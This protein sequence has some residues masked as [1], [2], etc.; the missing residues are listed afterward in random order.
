M[1]CSCRTSPSSRPPRSWP[2]S[3]RRRSSSMCCRTRSTS[4]PQASSARSRSA[5]R[6][7]LR[8]RAV[9]PVDLFGQPADY[10]ALLPIARGSGAFRPLR[11]GAE[12]RR[13]PRRRA[14]RPLRPRHGDELLSGEAA[15][16]LRRRRR[17]LHRRRRAR[18]GAALAPRA[19]PGQRQV[20]QCPHRRE[21]AAR[22]AA[23]GDPASRSWKSSPRRSSCARKWPRATA[24]R[25]ATRSRRRS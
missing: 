19:R 11:C 24:L 1:P 12:F 14:R 9:I 18:R 10:G 22:H 5:K 23:G 25:S 16:L 17:H 20:R 8:P 6:Q 4:I 7:G 3:A 13:E 15:R 2:G 21:R